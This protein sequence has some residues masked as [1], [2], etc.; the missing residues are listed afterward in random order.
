MGS[1]EERWLQISL[2]PVQ[3]FVT[4]ARKTQDLWAGSF[5]L[6]YLAAHLIAYVVEQGGQV[7]VPHAVDNALV[8]AVLE[9]EG[10]RPGRLPA[11]ARFGTVPNRMLA[12][13]PADFSG[14]ACANFMMEGW[15]QL[16]AGVHRRYVGELPSPSQGIWDRQVRSFWEVVWALSPP[17]DWAALD[18]RKLWWTHFPPPEPGDKC[19]LMTD[20]QELSGCSRSISQQQGRLQDEF[21]QSVQQKL[22][23]HTLDDR[24]RLSAIGLIKRLFPAY[25]R[26][27]WGWTGEGGYPSTQYLAAV[28]WLRTLA[29]KQPEPFIELASAAKAAGA[30]AVESVQY[31]PSLVAVGRDHPAVAPGLRLPGEVFHRRGRP[32]AAGDPNEELVDRLLNRLQR[33]GVAASPY[34]AIVI[35]DGD[36]MGRLLRTAPDAVTSALGRFAAQ[37]SNTVARYDAA[38][39]YA[40]GDDVLL[41][42]AMDQALAV[43][44]ALRDQYVEAFGEADD[45]TRRDATISA[46]VLYAHMKAPLTVALQEAHRLLEQEAKICAGRDSIA[47]GVCRDHGPDAQVEWA[48]RWSFLKGGGPD[49]DGLLDVAQV[50]RSGLGTS[51]LYRMVR[52]LERLGPEVEKLDVSGFLA[53]ERDHGRG[54]SLGAKDPVIQTLARFIKS[55]PRATAGLLAAQ[56]IVR[57]ER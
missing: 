56:F 12:E 37:V 23:P 24:E 40:G 4:R 9:A 29:R 53:A 15:H 43:A 33:E 5:L 31:F 6:S 39:V 21:W 46:A 20:L 26:Q 7:L 17:G 11:S 2:G 44:R 10:G 57:E 51:Y 36:H 30:Q 49:A 38:V 41:L 19:Q 48:G 42:A 47:V 35:M 52:M 22:P 34:Y 16:A 14:A 50:L 13:V 54:P 1:G 25:V 55:A 27:E 8:R 18:R 32:G 45:A 3:S 28:P